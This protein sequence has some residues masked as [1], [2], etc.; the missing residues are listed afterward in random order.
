MH[1][2]SDTVTL[3]SCA[4]WTGAG[5]SSY[6][7]HGTLLGFELA[8]GSRRETVIRWV[9]EIF[10]ALVRTAKLYLMIG[11]VAAALNAVA[12][13]APP[14]DT[15]FER[16]AAVAQDVVLWPRFLIGIAVA[17]DGRLAAMPIEDQPFLYSLLRGPYASAD[18]P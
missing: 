7:L 17:V 18:Q 2:L 13:H 6:A 4:L 5:E 8:P 1:A 11:I 12:F 10:E 15:S 14:G 16:A 9:M 3:L